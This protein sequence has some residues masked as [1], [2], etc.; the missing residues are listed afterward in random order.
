MLRI[1]RESAPFPK[2]KVYYYKIA[3]F[4]GYVNS[5][6]LFVDNSTNVN[7][8]QLRCCRFQ[9]YE[10]V[11][12]WLKLN[13]IHNSVF[14]EWG[15]IHVYNIATSNATYIYFFKL[16]FFKNDPLLAAFK[17]RFDDLIKKSQKVNDE[18][19]SV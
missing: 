10:N 15:R 13:G 11:Y 14:C 19:I 17:L 12:E 4:L 9:D 18:W 5:Y 3:K 2:W 6:T 8:D 16:H 1:Y 7:A